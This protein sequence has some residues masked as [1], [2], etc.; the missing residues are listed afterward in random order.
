MHS[1]S[2]FLK[3]NKFLFKALGVCRDFGY[4]AVEHILQVLVIFTGYEMIKE[5]L[6]FGFGS[7]RGRGRA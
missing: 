3:H 1:F 7:G 4:V 2:K 6:V 5:K